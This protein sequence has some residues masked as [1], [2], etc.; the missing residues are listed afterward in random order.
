MP[1]Q[2]GKPRCSDFKPEVLCRLIEESGINPVQLAL[3]AG[4]QLGTL[5]CAMLG[6]RHLQVPV[7]GRIAEV[8]GVDVWRFYENGD[9]DQ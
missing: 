9:D 8:L 6:L 5:A 1:S 4:V 3:R 7:A 2:A